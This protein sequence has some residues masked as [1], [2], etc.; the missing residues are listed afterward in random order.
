MHFRQGSNCGPGITDSFKRTQRRTPE[1]GRSELVFASSQY[2]GIKQITIAFFPLHP[3]F[4]P[5]TEYDPTE[6]SRQSFLAKSLFVAEL[7]RRL[8]GAG[9]SVTLLAN[10]SK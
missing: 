8:K 4:D 3:R 7:R 9:V 6:A 10:Q 2:I 5:S 1:V